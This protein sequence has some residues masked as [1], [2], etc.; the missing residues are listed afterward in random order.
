MMHH[1][2]R[3]SRAE[4]SVFP[5][6]RHITSGKKE[7]AA[8]SCDRPRAKLETEEEEEEEGASYSELGLDKLLDEF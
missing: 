1:T 4:T 3:W 7:S 5:T 6:E 2:D 8:D